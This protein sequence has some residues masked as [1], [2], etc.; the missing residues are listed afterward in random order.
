LQ[1]TIASGGKERPSSYLFG[2][3]PRSCD[4]P[5]RLERFEAAGA[6]ALTCFGFLAS[7]LLRFWPLAI[8]LAPPLNEVP[9]DFPRGLT[10]E[11]CSRATGESMPPSICNRGRQRCSHRGT[12]PTETC[13]Q[14]FNSRPTRSTTA[15]A[16]T[17]HRKLGGFSPPSPPKPRAPVCA[18]PRRAW[19]DRY[20]RAS[21]PLHKRGVWRRCEQARGHSH[22]GRP[23]ARVRPS[24]VR[25]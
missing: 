12:P 1:L 11:Q 6:L 25:T 24:T 14:G 7:L 5:S 22:E 20:G 21:G 23:R 4:S 10:A 8:V 9:R 18:G 17:P 16:S 13:R 15:I 19:I 3:L 2:L